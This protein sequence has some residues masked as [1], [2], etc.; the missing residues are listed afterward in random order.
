MLSAM[1]FTNFWLP[2]EIAGP[3]TGLIEEGEKPDR[4]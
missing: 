4:L 2:G 1:D 3:F